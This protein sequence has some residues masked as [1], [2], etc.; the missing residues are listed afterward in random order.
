MSSSRLLSEVSFGRGAVGWAED[1]PTGRMGVG[2]DGGVGGPPEAEAEDGVEL[3]QSK[4]AGCGNEGGGLG[5][6][7]LA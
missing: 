5:D 7:G 6:G 1:G 4:A 2:P 3:L